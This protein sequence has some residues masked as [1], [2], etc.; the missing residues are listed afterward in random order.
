MPSGYG[1]QGLSH[2][3]TEAATTLTP[4]AGSRSDD[5]ARAAIVAVTKLAAAAGHPISAVPGGSDAAGGGS[6]TAIEVRALVFAAVVLSAAVIW[7]R[8]QRREA[9]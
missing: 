3:A 1:V 5:L 9:R 4:P 8:R 2:P 6:P 7:L